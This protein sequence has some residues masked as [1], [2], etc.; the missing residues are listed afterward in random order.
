MLW[1]KNEKN[2]HFLTDY[3][4]VC[5]KNVVILQ[6]ICKVNITNGLLSFVFRLSTN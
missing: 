2:L 1:T 4:C 6:Q 5:P 3:T